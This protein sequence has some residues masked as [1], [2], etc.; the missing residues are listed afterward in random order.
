MRQARTML[1]CFVC[2]CAVSVYCLGGAWLH[3]GLR[4]APLVDVAHVKAL[5]DYSYAGYQFGEAVWQAAPEAKVFR[6]EEFG[7]Q[8]NDAG[9]DS[10][11]F[12]DCLKAA[13]AHPGPVVIAL[14]AGQYVLSEILPISRSDIALRGMGMGAGGTE[15]YFPRPLRMVR[16]GKRFAEIAQ[17][18][19]SENKLQ[20]EPERS[21]RL[22]FS[23]YSWTGGFIWIQAEGSRPFPYLESF[24]QAEAEP[25]AVRSGLRGAHA[26]TLAAPAGLQVGQAVRLQWRNAQGESGA[27]ID[28]IYG[29]DRSQ[30][31][32]KVGS[33]LWQDPKRAIVTQLSEIARVQGNK[34]W[35]RDPLLHPINARLPAQLSRWDALRQVALQDFAVRFPSGKSF[36][37][38][39]EEGYNAV[40]LTDTIHA[41]ISDIRVINADSA[42]LSYNTAASTISQV[43]SE[44]KRQAHYSVHLGN[45][46]GVLVQDLQVLNPTVHAL[47]FNTFCTRSVY[48]RAQVWQQGV[49][50]QHAGVNHQNLIDSAR[51]YV[52]TKPDAEGQPSYALWD[53]SGAGYWQPGHGRGN[54][55]WNVQVQVLSGAAPD[56]RVQLTGLDEG[57]GAW[58]VGLHGNR[59]F[60]LRYRPQPKVHSLNQTSPIASLYE[61][62]RQQRLKKSP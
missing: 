52:Q 54:T 48:L 14:E 12:L 20:I 55:H 59:S 49:I 42:V 10:A 8:V 5:P 1:C 37:H 24:A 56:A 36:G 26:L 17:Y 41:W 44:G 50:D 21:I 53:G 62:Q 6:V 13:H 58:I 22:P 25:V 27:L 45:V 38:H 19:R 15:L 35:L 40:Y 31:V 51:F 32:S 39:L 18:L 47:S 2:V 29:S 16:K 43:I 30:L 7:A 46:H 4:A 57:P 9:D 34:V 33:R 11:A 23:I 3:A 60:D 61:W 28:E